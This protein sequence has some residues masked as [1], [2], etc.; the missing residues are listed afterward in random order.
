MSDSAAPWTVAHQALLSAHGIPQARVLQWGATSFSRDLP[1][2]GLEPVSPA[3]AGGFFTTAPLG[4]PTLL[5]GALR[6]WRLALLERDFR[7]ACS[8]F[9]AHLCTSSPPH[10]VCKFT[11][12]LCHIYFGFHKYCSRLSLKSQSMYWSKLDFHNLHTLN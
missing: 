1:A 3:L 12:A 9:S 10:L 2:P 4:K 11:T 6:Q 8:L 7:A 5:L